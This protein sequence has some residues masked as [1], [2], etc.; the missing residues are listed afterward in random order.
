[1]QQR[2]TALTVMAGLLAAPAAPAGV[3]VLCDFEKDSVAKWA[4]FRRQAPGSYS[5]RCSG[6]YGCNFTAT[7]GPATSGQWALSARF[8]ARGPCRY[9]PGV[10]DRHHLIARK[11]FSTSYSL[12]RIAPTDWTPFAA[13]AFNLWKDKPGKVA[14]AVALEDH[15]ISPPVVRRFELLEPRRWHTLH[16]PLKELGQLLDLKQMVNFWVIVEQSPQNVE[17]RLDDIRLVP[18]GTRKGPYPLLED[19]RPVKEAYR[20]LVA[21]LASITPAEARHNVNAVA[22]QLHRPPPPPGTDPRSF[23]RPRRIERFAPFLPARLKLKSFTRRTFPYGLEFFGDRAAILILYPGRFAFTTNAGENWQLAPTAFHGVNSWRCEATGD[24]GEVLLV[25]MGQCCGGGLPSSFYFRRLIPGPAGWQ[26]G[27]AW[28]VDRDARHCP[29]HFDILRLPTGRLWAAWNH[30]RRTGGYDLRAK[31]S[32]DDGRSWKHLGPS[33]AIPA[34]DAPGDPKLVPFRRSVACLWA[35]RGGVFFSTA[36]PRRW[37]RPARLPAARLISAAS[38]D[39]KTVLAVVAGPG[40]TDPLRV[41]SGDG[42][43]WAEELRPPAAGHLTVEIKTGRVHLVGV[44]LKAGTPEVFVTTRH[45]TGKWSAPR[46]VPVAP[47]AQPAPT[48]LAVSLTRYSPKEFL[49]IAVAGLTGQ[50]AWKTIKWVQVIKLPTEE[51]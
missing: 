37:A 48:A 14:L 44:V 7:I 29:D 45:P 8:A 24:R 32:D 33:P 42:K 35:G 43:S 3:R 15:L 49:P 41:L 4:R 39:G 47:P 21:E 11:L 31:Y 2:L 40:K 20:R 10:R 27:P 46:F 12:A 25:G 13:L 51:N 30:C 19:R 9:L 5:A 16:L 38:P 23:T 17:L 28:P 1:M 50:R 22:G 18:P 26:L 6:C 34:S 36:G